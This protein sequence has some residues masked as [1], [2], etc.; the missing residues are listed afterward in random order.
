MNKAWATLLCVISLSLAACGGGDAT[1][2]PASSAPGV[3]MATS[4]R[5]PAL[6][7]T[8]AATVDTGAAYD[9]QPTATDAD[10]DTLRFSITNKPVWAAFDPSTG[11]LSGTP[12]AADIG[13]V[14]NIVISVSD[15]STSV[16][17]PTFAVQVTGT[18]TLSWSAP[19]QNMDGTTLRDLSGYR[20]YYGSSAATMVAVATVTDPTVSS[21][22]VGGLPNGTWYFAISAVNAAG[23]ESR[24][25]NIGSKTLG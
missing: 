11:R 7:G 14:A 5:A 3:A 24:L 4:N 2:A 20:I 13:T 6:S 1:T 21:Y 9:F 22:R 8:P 10:G 18:A 17:L 16:S 19:T 23:V 15:G 25:S 12:T